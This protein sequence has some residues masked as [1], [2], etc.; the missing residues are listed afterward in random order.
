LP[1][2]VLAS[3]NGYV[4]GLLVLSQLREAKSGAITLPASGRFVKKE[5]LATEI[6]L[7]RERDAWQGK[8]YPF[9]SG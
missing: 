2:T 1:A 5:S 3:P 9:P 8:M 6:I 7:V 4:Q